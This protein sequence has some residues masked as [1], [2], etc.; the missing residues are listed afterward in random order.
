MLDKI[1]YAKYAKENNKKI[2]VLNQGRKYS[3]LYYY[4]DK[5]HYIS[6]D[7]DFDENIL[8]DKNTVTVVRNKQIPQ[9][10]EVLNLETINEGRKF[11]LVKVN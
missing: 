2:A 7:E 10:K 3:V 1:F 11:S 6:T 5:V 8:K 9:I 4:G